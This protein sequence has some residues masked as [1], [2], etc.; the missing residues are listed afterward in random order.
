MAN[1]Q[2]R[3]TIDTEVFDTSTPVETETG[4]SPPGE[5]SRFHSQLFYFLTV[6]H[7]AFLFASSFVTISSTIC[8]FT[9]ISEST[10]DTAF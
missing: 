10:L 6:I 7:I 4:A 3:E 5:T 1:D 9:P 2:R 8:S